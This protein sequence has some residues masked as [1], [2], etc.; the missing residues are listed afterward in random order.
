MNE[1]ISVAAAAE[2]IRNGVALSI[3]G[4]AGALRTLP[5]GPWIGGTIPYFMVSGGGVVVGDDRVFVTDLSKVGA[6]VRIACYGPDE[7]A[8]ITAEAFDNGF[9]LTIIPAGGQAHGRFAREATDSADA[10]LKP[11]VGWISG[12]HLDDMGR[13]HALVFDGRN[14]REVEDGAVVAHIRLPDDKLASVEIVNIFEQDDGDVLRFD[15]VGFEATECTVNGERVNLAKYLQTRGATDGRLPLVGDYAGAGI[16]VSFQSIDVDKG[17]VA[18]YAPVFTGIDYRLARPVG[19][20]TAEFRRRLAEYDATGAVFS[21]NCILN[22]LFGELEGKA[23]GGVEGPV[24]FGEI[25]YQL[26]NQTMVVVRV[27]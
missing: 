5:A 13:A 9:S 14:G 19:D 10:F 24:T 15:Q 26:L 17:Q 25:A 16:N 6:E 12:I 21:C 20:Y 8:R 18:F 1:L 2:L 23:I 7:L 3:A 27:H 11:T 22:F 4:T